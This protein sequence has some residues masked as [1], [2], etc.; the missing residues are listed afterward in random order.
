MK[1]MVAIVAIVLPFLIGVIFLGN[2]AEKKRLKEEYKVEENEKESI[3]EF[4][5]LVSDDF[6]DGKSDRWIT[7]PLENW[8]VMQDG[9]EKV[10]ALIEPGQ[11]REFRAPGAYALLKDFDVTDFVFIGKIKSYQDSQISS[12]DM[13]VIFHYQD[14]THFYYVHFSKI[15][16]Q[17][18]NIIA[19]VNG[20]DREKI[21]HELAGD[22]QARLVDNEF[23]TF[24]VCYERRTSGICAY[25]D[26]MEEPI[27]TAIDSTL[28]HGLV[29]V[30]SFDD[31]GCVDDI[32]LWGK[33][34]RY[35]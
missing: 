20:R 31:T 25:L 18:H 35:K 5:L 24:K 8:K 22:S 13:V 28:S 6:E 23:H 33:K 15:S 32:V 2:C 10:F 9:N 16:D 3:G 11:Q 27:L 17:V 21:N 19:I 1:K 12:R 26:D 34:F 4:P 7:Y 30:G 29:G 14:P